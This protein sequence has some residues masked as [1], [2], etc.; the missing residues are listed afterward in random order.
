M[1]TFLTA[2]VNR[3]DATQELLALG[4][5]NICNSLVTGYNS[6]GGLTKASVVN[7]SGVRTQLASLYAASLVILALLFLAPG[8]FY[9]PKAT[10]GAI[11]ISAIIFVVQYDKVLPIWRTKSEFFT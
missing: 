9:I 11:V 8:I 2:T 5:G 1:F 4:F 7:S 3:I 10:L 6:C